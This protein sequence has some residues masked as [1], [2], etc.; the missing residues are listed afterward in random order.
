MEGCSGRC[1]LFTGTLEDVCLSSFQSVSACLLS[2]CELE[3]RSLL[4][5]QRGKRWWAGLVRA[6]GCVSK[7]VVFRSILKI[8]RFLLTNQQKTT[9]NAEFKK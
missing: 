5:K 2:V 6:C 1:R 8:S 4:M 7:G 3:R 9:T